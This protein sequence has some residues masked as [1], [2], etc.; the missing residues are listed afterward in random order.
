MKT[1]CETYYPTTGCH[2]GRDCPE[3]ALY[4]ELPITLEDEPVPRADRWI[5]ALALS[6]V[7]WALLSIVAAAVVFILS[8]F[9]YHLAPIAVYAVGRAVA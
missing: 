3:R 9:I 2:Q 7:E 1:C 4:R 8:F 6:P 5:A